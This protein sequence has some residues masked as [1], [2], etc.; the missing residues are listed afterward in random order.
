MD[1]NDSKSQYYS[2]VHNY[3]KNLIASSWH[4]FPFDQVLLERYE[5]IQQLF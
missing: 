1:Q 3:Q 4:I 2:D 5:V